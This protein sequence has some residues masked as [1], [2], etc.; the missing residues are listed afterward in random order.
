[1]T[2]TVLSCHKEQPFFIS[3]LQSKHLNTSTLLVF[4]CCFTM[5]RYEFF[6][7]SQRVQ[8]NKT[9]TAD[10]VLPCEGNHFPEIPAFLHEKNLCRALFFAARRQYGT[11]TH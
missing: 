8:Q 7:K 5:Q 10:V 9:A 1:M 2:F 4:R 3:V 6:S 11:P